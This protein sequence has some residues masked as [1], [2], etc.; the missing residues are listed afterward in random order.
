MLPNI[1]FIP[2]IS[3]PEHFKNT[4]RPVVVDDSTIFATKLHNTPFW[5]NVETC[6]LNIY[7]LPCRSV[8]IF[9]NVIAGDDLS[10]ESQ[11]SARQK[12]KRIK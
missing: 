9:L 8:Y 3:N 12:E 1:L 4:I 6:L 5:L 11:D 2:N 7:A 10:V